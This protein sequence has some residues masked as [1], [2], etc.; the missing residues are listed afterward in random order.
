M[1]EVK[2]LADSLTHK[3]NLAF[4]AEQSLEA[5]AEVEQALWKALAETENLV[6]SISSIL[7]GLDDRNQI[8][9]WNSASERMFG[10]SA[11]SRLGQVFQSSEI[12]WD[13]S[14]IMAA[15]T[16]CR[17]NQI[18][19]QIPEIR[20]VDQ[21]GKE[22]FL[23]LTVSPILKES[24]TQPGLLLLGTSITKQKALEAQLAIT[25]KMESIGQLAAGVAH[26]I[27]TPIH[28]V[29]ENVR[30]L[31]ESFQDLHGLLDSYSRFLETSQAG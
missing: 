25:Q 19:V 3:W 6:A 5:L 17:K 14:V 13:W 30:F 15:L 4:Q 7:I 31:K 1:I 10:Y 29:A 28:Y 2:Q 22:E 12:G 21:M 16:D 26:E 8:I 27:N 20:Y 24:G 9:R 23:S 18:P 11:S